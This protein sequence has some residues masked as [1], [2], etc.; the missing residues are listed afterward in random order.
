M[1]EVKEVRAVEGCGHTCVDMHKFCP[2]SC[3]FIKCLLVVAVLGGVFAAGFVAGGEEGGRH[4]GH[5]RYGRSEGYRG[6]HMMMP[7]YQGW[8]NSAGGTENMQ[9]M[10]RTATQPVG[11][12][13]VDTATSW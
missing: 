4:G 5:E 9:M 2:K 6:G 3:C 8:D 1:E 7:D 12:Q 10:Y 11:Q 13:S